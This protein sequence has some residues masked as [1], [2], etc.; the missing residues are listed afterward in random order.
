MCRGPRYLCTRAEA[1]RTN[2]EGHRTCPLNPK[3]V[4][5]TRSHLSEVDSNRKKFSEL[6]FGFIVHTN[7]LP[8]RST[9]FGSNLEVQHRTLESTGT[10]TV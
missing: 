8:L 5:S 10:Q 7:L 6:I 3:K 9:I 2:G 1:G 4:L